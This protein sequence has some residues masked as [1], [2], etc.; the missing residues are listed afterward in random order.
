M[1]STSSSSS[2]SLS[3]GTP[4]SL[5]KKIKNL[6]DLYEITNHID[7]NVTLYCHLIICDPIVFKE[8]IKYKK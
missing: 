3:S 5:P 7:D 6:N 2:K 1:C 4:P 8:S